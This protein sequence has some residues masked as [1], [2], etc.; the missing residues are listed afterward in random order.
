MEYAE[1]SSPGWR[2]LLSKRTGVLLA[3][4]FIIV[5]ISPV[6]GK[7]PSHINPENVT[8][9]SSNL[10]AQQLAL[11][12]E[13]L[14]YRGEIFV[15][16]KRGNFTE[17]AEN[18]D[19]YMKILKENDNILIQIEGNTYAELKA[20]AN[21]LNL[22]HDEINQLRA[23]YE[24]GK[25]AYRN[26]DTNKAI[27][28][29]LLARKIIRNLSSQEK[30]MIM[31]AVAQY[32]GV[33]ITLYQNGLSSFDSIVEDI[34]KR[35]LPIE[36]TLFDETLIKLSL[37][38]AGGEFG[39]ELS[40]D[41]SLVLLR[42]TSGISHANIEVKLDNVTAAALVT[43]K[44]G[45][46][47]YTFR[48]P[49]KKIGNHSIQV[50]FVPYDEPLLPS[51]AKS[52]FF[53]RP[54]NTTL[55]IKA[56]PG[57]GEFGDIL[58]ITGSLTAKNVSVSDADITISLD[59]KSLVSV[60]TDENG[61]YN[62]DFTIPVITR[63]DHRVAA[64]FIPSTQPLFQSRNT[65]S[66]NVMQANT[67]ITIAG[68]KTVYQ[69]D[70]LNITG[71]LRTLKNHNVPASN[72]TVLLD[73]G[74]IGIAP[75]KDGDFSYSIRIAKN[76][77]PG[78]HIVVVRFNGE[79]L[80]LQSENSM[81]VE[82][83][84]KPVFYAARQ[85]VVESNHSVLFLILGIVGIVLS[86]FYLRKEKV[87]LSRIDALVPAIRSRFQKAEKNQEPQI[88]P[89]PLEELEIEKAV[90]PVKA[91]KVNEEEIYGHMQELIIQKQFRESI[92][93]AF[94]NAKDC[95]STKSGFKNTLVLTH[96]EFYDLVRNMTAI[97]GDFK[98]LAGLY[99]TAMYSN[100]KIDKEEALEA[101]YLLKEIYNLSRQ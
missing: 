16:L 6:S 67:T 70:H 58:R 40:L 44:Q 43:D 59:N 26:N 68:P 5:L 85:K 18:L 27:R 97:A 90:P 31:T 45:K 72:I 95:I 100:T 84:I 53:I 57:Y 20:S 46:F 74:I 42:N 99:E 54:A 1:C 36:L 63:G 101:L 13:L 37:Y 29:A 14:F 65:T 23:L 7:I 81:P 3:F 78:N 61:L 51:S 30:E 77:S 19:N 52:T 50:D 12:N 41:G 91:K 79:S 9:S 71:K 69:D 17:A 25:A 10:Y 88:P 76:M 32:P 64:D 75:V 87:L 15:S 24:E 60:K 4:L 89:E 34:R 2:K 98:E 56:D 83:R 73:K 28:I 55:T 33:N 35:W 39:N 47:N 22:T 96:W 82:I 11:I 62:Y 21:T 93:F 48:V 66:V 49:Y 8:A 92:S 86:I 94:E 80:F 38:P